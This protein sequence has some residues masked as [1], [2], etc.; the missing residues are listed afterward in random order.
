MTLLLCV[1]LLAKALPRLLFCT[2]EGRLLC[3]DAVLMAI[4][5]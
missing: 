1:L 5:L 3:G 4:P 2:L